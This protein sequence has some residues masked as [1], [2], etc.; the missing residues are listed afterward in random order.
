[1]K[2]KESKTNTHLSRTSFLSEEGLVPLPED[3][4]IPTVQKDDRQEIHFLPQPRRIR[5]KRRREFGQRS[6][7]EAPNLPAKMIEMSGRS[8]RTLCELLSSG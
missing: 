1:M 3:L 2:N 6:K 4:S 5:A 7:S 8:C